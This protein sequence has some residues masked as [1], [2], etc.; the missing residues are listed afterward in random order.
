MP[1]WLICTRPYF[2]GAIHAAQEGWRKVVA[3][4]AEHG[5]RSQHLAQRY[6]ITM[7]SHRSPPKIFTSS[8]RLLLPTATSA[9][10]KNVPT[11]LTGQNLVAPS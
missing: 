4:A 7:I 6:L 10:T 5:G 2:S 9:P 11:T 8:A 1:T 3:L